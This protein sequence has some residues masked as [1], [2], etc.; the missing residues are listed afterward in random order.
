MEQQGQAKLCLWSV[1][2]AEC[3]QNLACILP[4][5]QRRFCQLYRLSL[6]TFTRLI[7]SHSLI[8]VKLPPFHRLPL[9]RRVISFFFLNN[10]L[11]LLIYPLD[12]KSRCALGTSN[13]RASRFSCP[14]SEMNIYNVGETSQEN[15]KL[16]KGFLEVKSFMSYLLSIC[17]LLLFVIL[18]RRA[19]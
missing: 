13:I 5:F 7:N 3:P 19:V 1:T 17:A 16:H 8:R 4:I 2:R 9:R 15:K 14:D 12:T 6:R 11:V 18:Q 10:L